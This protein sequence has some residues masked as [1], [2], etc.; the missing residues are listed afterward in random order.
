M[1]QV[2]PCRTQTCH[3]AKGRSIY[4]AMIIVMT[5]RVART[6]GRTGTAAEPQVTGKP[7][8]EAK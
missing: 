2:K 1:S 3:L 7:I 5:R 4:W 8:R 6:T